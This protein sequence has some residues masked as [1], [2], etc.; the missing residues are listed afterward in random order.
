M[1][2]VIKTGGKQYSVESG[3][4][5]KVEKINGKKGDS[6]SFKDILIIENSGEHT[7]GNPLIK[8]ASVEATIIAQIRDKKITVF[9]KKRRQNYRRTKGHRQY[10]TVVKIDKISDSKSTKAK[11]AEN[12]EK[13]TIV[14]KEVKTKENTS[15]SKKVIKKKKTLSKIKKTIKKDK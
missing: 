14:K 12:K 8:G 1:F 13:E 9:K 5:L 11:S 15:S 7:L 2:A 10:L 3:K 4:T 6:Y